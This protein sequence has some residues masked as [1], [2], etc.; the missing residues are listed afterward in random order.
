MLMTGTIYGRNNEILIN[1]SLSHYLSIVIRDHGMQASW[2]ATREITG[3]CMFYG[4]TMLTLKVSSYGV[5]NDH[6]IT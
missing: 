5:R 3:R 4:Q 1:A 6:E 2:R